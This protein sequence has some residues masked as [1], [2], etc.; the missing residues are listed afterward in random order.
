LCYLSE[1]PLSDFFQEAIQLEAVKEETAKITLR[2]A[3]AD[4]E[5]F[6]YQVYQSTRAEELAAWGWDASQ[7]EL[8]LKLQLKARDQSYLMHYQKLDDRVI[9]CGDEKVGRMIVSRN[10]EEIRLV[11]ISLLPQY[12]NAGIGTFLIEALFMEAGARAVRLQVDKANVRARRL[13]ERMGFSLRSETQTHLQ[14]ER[15]ERQG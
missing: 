2:P 4:D 5:N 1:P 15:N 6:L 12:R 14:M 3:S 8:F 13:Y 10:A 11:D 9:L 7:Q